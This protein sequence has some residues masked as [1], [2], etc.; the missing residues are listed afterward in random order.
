MKKLLCLLL[1]S[2][3][4][5]P[6]FADTTYPPNARYVIVNPNGRLKAATT[7]LLDTKT[8]KTW[9]FVVDSAGMNSWQQLQYDWYKQ[10]GTFGGMTFK[11]PAV[12]SP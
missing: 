7:F 6:V 11:A 3:I 2:F 4:I 10:D 5:S 1:L 12:T 9:Q 8:G